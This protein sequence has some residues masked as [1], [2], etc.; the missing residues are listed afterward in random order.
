MPKGRKSDAILLQ[1][2]KR[3]KAEKSNYFW[4]ICNACEMKQRWQSSRLN[5]HLDNCPKRQQDDKAG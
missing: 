4:A 5:R 2:F 1:N 3:V